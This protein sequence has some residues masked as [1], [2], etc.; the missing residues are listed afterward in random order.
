VKAAV[1]SGALPSAYQHFVIF[2]QFE[3]RTATL[4]NG[5][6]ISG[7]ITLAGNGTGGANV[8]TT[9][10]LTTGV[11]N[12]V[13][14][15]NADTIAAVSSS[16]AGASTISAA[17]VI[18]GNSGTDT[19]NI[20]VEGTATATTG[21]ADIQ[22]VEIV[23]VRNVGTAT[24]AID[25]GAV[26]G[27]TQIWSD[28]STGD[29][30]VTNLATG[31][32]GG[33]RGNNVATTTDASFGYATAAAAATLAFDGGTK[34]GAGAVNATLDAAGAAAEDAA[35]AS[36]T[37]TSAPTSVT[38]NSTGAANSIN[39]VALGGAATALTIN[40]T[41]AFTVAGAEATS[42]AG[43]AD[44]TLSNYITGFAADAVITTTGAGAVNLGVLEANVKE[45]NASGATGGLTVTGGFGATD[46]FT[47]GAGNDTLTVSAAITTGSATGGAGVDRL[48]VTDSAAVAVAGKIT[49]FEIL[50]AAG[51]TDTYDFANLAGITSVEIDGTAG[52]T[53]T[54]ASSQTFTV[55][56]DTVGDISITNPAFNPGGS[57]AFSL[58]FDNSVLKNADGVDAGALTVTNVD[59]LNISSVGANL[60]SAAQSNSIT[61]LA[62]SLDLNIVNITGDTSFSLTTGVSGVDTFNAASF[63][64]VLTLDAS[65]N[66]VGASITSGTANDS[67]IGSGFGDVI[68]AGAGN[69]TITAG[70]GFDTVNL[71]AGVND[72]LVLTG[73]LAEANRD[74]VTGF[75]VGAAGTAGLDKVTI[76]ATDT[77]LNTA[78]GAAIVIQDVATAP[79]AALTFNTAAADAVELSFNLRGDGVVG[80]DLDGAIDG[81][82]LL[83]ALGQTVSV[84]ADTNKGYIVAYQGSNAYL[85]YAQ[86]GADGDTALAATDIHLVGVFNNVAVGGFTADN[87]NLA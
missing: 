71:T 11:D 63:T 5:T 26:V 23:N 66:A 19:L 78:P 49:G 47:G 6:V 7:P 48:V 39:T 28:R 53:F 54:G 70:N 33:V 81:T 36:V 74:V 85:Y 75:T 13:G 79:T 46:K 40:A 3:G 12:I 84:S 9:F 62:S 27:A 82:N 34:A 42:V 29:V 57:D 68:N 61:S 30:T 44:V 72:T 50:R 35:I 37:I 24:A 8:G 1:N 41:T 22:G 52:V 55:I 65:G 60:S 15:S 76:G 69:N 17:D 10:T 45:V 18:R 4:N 83:A 73:V 25:G 43:D 56:G 20:T 86:E 32:V 67:I 16:T 2:G 14:T 21:G 59:V 77:T 87:F 51:T 64:G 58:A 80:Q 31:A 38:L